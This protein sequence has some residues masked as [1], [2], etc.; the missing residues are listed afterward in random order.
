VAIVTRRVFDPSGTIYPNY[1]RAQYFDLKS[2]AAQGGPIAPAK[3]GGYE[4]AV[5]ANASGPGYAGV[6]VGENRFLPNGKVMLSAN[7]P[8]ARGLAARNPSMYQLPDVPDNQIAR[9]SSRDAQ[10][11]WSPW[12]GDGYR[13]VMDANNQYTGQNEAYDVK[14][15]AQG[16][17]IDEPVIG[18]GQRTGKRYVFGEAGPEKVTPTPHNTGRQIARAPRGPR[19]FSGRDYINRQYLP[20][21]DERSR[22]LDETPFSLGGKNY[23]TYTDPASGKQVVR[24]E[25]SGIVFDV[26]GGGLSE[27]L[28]LSDSSVIA[29]SQITDNPT[30]QDW[31][32]P[33][34]TDTNFKDEF[35]N[36]LNQQ[37]AE[38]QAQ[39]QQ[40]LE[41]APYGDQTFGGDVPP[42]PPS[43]TPPPPPV[44]IQP[45]GGAQFDQGP[46][47]SPYDWRTAQSLPYGP[48][49]P[50]LAPV[51]PDD[52]AYGAPNPTV[53]PDNSGNALDPGVGATDT[54]YAGPPSPNY[55]SPEGTYIGT[56]APPSPESFDPLAPYNPNGPTLSPDSMGLI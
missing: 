14:S 24:D 33:L 5:P 40:Q 37:Q 39:Q 19:R 2:T 54:E 25:A 12:F 29:D 20:N 9:G 26:G 13:P 50:P 43:E 17:M 55:W 15:Y 41:V 48:Y 23:V 16:G 4:G 1:L 52:S 31:A 3:G 38:Q 45:S 30:I 42:P 6:N 7:D 35:V 28:P 21:A 34:S 32:A 36:E 18:I 53:S 27:T 11:N 8:D 56:M 10:G 49:V 46:T 51:L 22:A 44:D 47:A